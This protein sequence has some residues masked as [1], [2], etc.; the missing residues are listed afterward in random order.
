MK[1]ELEKS[2]LNL[3]RAKRELLATLWGTFW[4]LVGGLVIGYMLSKLIN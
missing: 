2:R 3:E 4:G 1:K